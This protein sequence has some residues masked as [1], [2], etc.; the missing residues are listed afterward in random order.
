MQASPPQVANC[1]TNASSTPLPSHAQLAP[2]TP[3]PTR[4]ISS[5]ELMGNM[6][7][8]EIEHAGSLYRLRLTSLGK[9]ILTK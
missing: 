3:P 8:L 6:R 5:N 7:E 1:Q 9:L 4:R 2:H